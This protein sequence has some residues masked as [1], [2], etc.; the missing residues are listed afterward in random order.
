MI[1]IVYQF[2]E[3]LTIIICLHYLYGKKLALDK[4]TCLFIVFYLSTCQMILKYDL[5]R[6]ASLCMYPVL[7][8]YCFWKFRST[9]RKSVINIVM[10]L[11]LVSAFQLLF[12]FPVIVRIDELRDF[13]IFMVNVLTLITVV[14]LQRK[15]NLKVFSDFIYKQKFVCDISFGIIFSIILAALIQ[16][17][18]EYTIGIFT[19]IMLIFFIGMY[20]AFYLGYMKLQNA[21]RE[22]D[23]SLCLHKKYEQ[24]YEELIRDIRI[25][26]H[27][28]N[29][30]ITAIYG[31]IYTCDSLD[32]LVDAQKSYCEKLVSDT[33]LYKLLRFK[34]T[35]ISGFLYQKLCDIEK[36]EIKLKCDVKTDNFKVSM[37]ETVLVE[38]LGILIDNAV[39]EAEKTDE[40]EIVVSVE[41]TEKGIQVSVENS[42]RPIAETELSSMFDLGSSTKGERR[43]IGL[44]KVKKYCLEY[45][46]QIVVEADRHREPM[47]FVIRILLK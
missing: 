17:K 4:G 26:Q 38:I 29:N 30:H 13:V 23:E 39:E 14:L 2:V 46:A 31:Q 47:F 21:I 32:E 3:I 20:I 24:S 45:G 44:F 12:I 36:R 43:G 37:P 40:K 16:F 28:F 6:I 34:D 18:L 1:S 5:P 27:D 9:F 35:V 15:V 19:Y 33:Q 7:G 22:K 10:C 42:S 8:G 11:I 25:K 41:E